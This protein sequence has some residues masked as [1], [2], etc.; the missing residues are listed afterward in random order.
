MLS[1]LVEHSSE[2][3]CGWL[4]CKQQTEK[5]SPIPDVDGANQY[6]CSLDR[7]K[8]ERRKSCL[9]L[10]EGRSIFNTAFECLSSVPLGVQWRLF[11]LP[12]QTFPLSNT[13]LNQILQWAPGLEFSSRLSYSLALRWSFCI[14]LS[15]IPQ[16]A[17]V[18]L[19][20]KII[21]TIIY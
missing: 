1:R 2:D 4:T 9:L 21:T 17:I 16:A 7:I 12:T 5:G 3:V 8:R 20:S 19:L 15:L 11:I 13:D 6:V 18:S 14:L 10:L